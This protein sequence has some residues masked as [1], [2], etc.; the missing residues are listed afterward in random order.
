VVKPVALSI[1]KGFTTR[2]PN[3]ISSK[4]TTVKKTT[5]QRNFRQWFIATLVVGVFKGL[6]RLSVS[7]KASR[8]KPQLEHLEI[9]YDSGQLLSP[10]LN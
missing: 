3:S 10:S 7:T 6:A 9:V 1:V 5:L 2:M 8:R 4:T